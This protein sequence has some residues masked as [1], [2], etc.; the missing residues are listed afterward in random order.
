MQ[1]NNIRSCL[2]IM[3]FFS[4]AI[5]L[6]EG[7]F[8]SKEKIVARIG[9]WQITEQ[10]IVQKN[11]LNKILNPQEVRELGESQLKDIFKKAIIVENYGF[12]VNPSVLELEAE[13]FEKNFEQQNTLSQIKNIFSN[14][15]LDYLNV[16]IL[17]IWLERTLR[18]SIYTDIENKRLKNFTLEKSKTPF[19]AIS[20]EEWLESEIKKSSSL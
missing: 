16:Y 9:R 7:C 10:N 15:H 4:F 3:L 20:F 13:N 11:Q 14:Q 19:Q 6:L 5:V 18:D 8:F 12:H 2:K 1:F 17:P